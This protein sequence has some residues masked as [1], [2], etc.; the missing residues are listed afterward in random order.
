MHIVRKDNDPEDNDL[1]DNRT[2][3]LIR[4]NFV[5]ATAHELSGSVMQITSSLRSVSANRSGITRE[6]SDASL[7]AAVAKGDAAAFDTLFTRHQRAVYRF[8]LRFTKDASLAEET[9]S[10]VFLEVWRCAGKFE[11]RSQVSTW[12]LAIARYKAI[13][14]LRQ[15]K[16]SQLESSA[17]VLLEDSADNPEQSLVKQQ[18]GAIVRRCLSQLPPAHR[19]IIDLYYLG[20]K[21]IPELADLVG[22]PASTVKTRMFYAR[23]RMAQ[24]LEQAGMT[25]TRA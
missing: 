22:I 19:Q 20:H 24:L 6:R 9:A 25:S 4:C 1:E 3:D 8:V 14:L 23:N 16:E 10:E 18:S 21:S 12:L 13:A 11:A 7:L 17:D 2:P 5:N 15:R